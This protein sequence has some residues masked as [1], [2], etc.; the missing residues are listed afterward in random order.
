MIRN[1]KGVAAL[2]LASFIL[3]A[4]KIQTTN[5]RPCSHAKYADENGFHS[6]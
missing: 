6:V 4:A 5:T 3:V 1:L 2:T